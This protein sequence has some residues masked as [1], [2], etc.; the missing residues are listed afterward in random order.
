M[1]AGSDVQQYPFTSREAAKIKKEG[2]VAGKA[3]TY[4]GAGRIVGRYR[5]GSIPPTLNACSLNC[6]FTIRKHHGSTAFLGG[7]VFQ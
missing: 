4:R 6:L 5:I 1:Q 7:S 2:K 3:S